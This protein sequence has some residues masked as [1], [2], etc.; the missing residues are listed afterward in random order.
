VNQITAAPAF[1]YAA[2]DPQTQAIVTVARDRIRAA[3][4]RVAGEFVEIG[5]ELLAVKQALP[6]GA[7]L[8][9]LGAEFG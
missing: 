8:E 4:R 1:D 2:L 3:G 9:W 5:A 6:H 7:F